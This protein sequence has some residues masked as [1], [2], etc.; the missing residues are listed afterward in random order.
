MV[1]KILRD[2]AQ[3]DSRKGADG[4]EADARVV[5]VREGLGEALAAGLDN[6]VDTDR[7]VAQGGVGGEVLV[8]VGRDVES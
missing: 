6:A 3:E 8:E 5:H 7:V 2:V 4:A 1:I